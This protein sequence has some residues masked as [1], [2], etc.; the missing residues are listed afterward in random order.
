[1]S[2]G[3]PLL[4]TVSASNL[5]RASELWSRWSDRVNRVPVGYHDVSS[6]HPDNRRAIH[7]D[8]TSF[9]AMGPRARAVMPGCLWSVAA[10]WATIAP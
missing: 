3:T 1:M 8:G 5:G 6:R 2:V 9:T 10:L 4:T 7:V